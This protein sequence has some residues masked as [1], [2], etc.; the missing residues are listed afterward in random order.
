MANNI[1][2]TCSVETTGRDWLENYKINL[3][4]FRKVTRYN[5]SYLF[6]LGLHNKGNK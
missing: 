1:L 6:R 2:G 5:R 4:V 3:K